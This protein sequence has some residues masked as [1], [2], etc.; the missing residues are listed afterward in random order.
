MPLPRSSD[1]AAGPAYR[2]LRQSMMK[3]KLLLYCATSTFLFAMSLVWGLQ[4]NPDVAGNL[5]GELTQ[6]LMPLQ[7]LPP[8]ALFAVIFLNNAIKA[9]LAIALGIVIGIPPVFFLCFN[10][11]SI[12]AIVSILQSTMDNGLIIASLA[13]HGIIEIPAL[14]LATALGLMVGFES[15]KFLTGRQSNVKMQMR[16]SFVIYVRW[17]LTALF[18]AALIE[19]FLTPLLVTWLGGADLIAP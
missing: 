12:G 19:A 10:G 2:F 17:I 15:L 16:Q 9:L 3:N 13:P 18:V 1:I 6:S 7:S 14:V 4:V 8:A 11:F 5:L